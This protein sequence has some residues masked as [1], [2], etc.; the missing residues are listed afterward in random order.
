MLL[1]SSIMNTTQ[2]HKF[3]FSK[4]TNIKLL[5]EIEIFNI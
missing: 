5:L 3:L 4:I 1:M 2:N